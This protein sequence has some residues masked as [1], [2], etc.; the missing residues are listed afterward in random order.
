MSLFLLALTA[1]LPLQT[2]NAQYV[3]VKERDGMYLRVGRKICGLVEFEQIPHSIFWTTF[4]WDGKH[5][6]KISKR[7]KPPLAYTFGGALI[8]AALIFGIAK[9]NRRAV[10]TTVMAMI[11]MFPIIA[12]GQ[13]NDLDQT[14][15]I[16]AMI[17]LEEP[18]RKMSIYYPSNWKATDQRPALVIFRSNM[19]EQREHLRKLGMVVIK[20]QTAPVNSGNLPKMTLEEIANSAK[21][22]DQVADTKS[23]IRFIRANAEKLGID[24]KKIVAMGTSGGGDLALQS[25]LN[26]AF[27]HESDDTSV[28]CSPD[29]LVLYCPAFD[30]IDIWFVKAGEIQKRIETEAPSFKKYTDEFYKVTGDYV[31]P[32]DHRKTL[33]EL[34]ETVGVAQK[35]PADQ[36]AAFQEIL[37]LFNERDW[38]LLHPVEDA[39][40]GSAFRILTKDPLPPTIILHGTRDHLFQYQTAF[41]KKAR[42]MGQQFEVKLYEGAGH[43]FMMQPAFEKPS[44]ADVQAFLE[45]NGIL[46]FN[47]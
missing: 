45:E 20:P 24:P 26:R 38:Q 40:K 32:L 29:V 42:E 10:T 22:R 30:G 33:F 1:L 28:S 7:L 39:L 36:I 3:D 37:K 35:I 13:G 23:A 25:H 12:T 19:P 34:A 18:R 9:V 4:L 14:A 11:I 31:T 16:G 6:F 21:P 43:S 27:Q 46:P 2:A 44:T 41:I 5:V 15:K 17:Y 47:D 8:I